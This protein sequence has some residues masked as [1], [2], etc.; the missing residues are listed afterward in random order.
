MP[1]Q[2]SQGDIEDDKAVK[3][4]KPKKAFEINITVWDDAEI[5]TK[6][7][8]YV[9]KERGAPEK[10]LRKPDQF[11]SSVKDRISD[12]PL[13]LL[14]VLARTLNIDLATLLNKKPA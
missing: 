8:E 13:L 4:P 2:Q 7:N 11:V 5:T 14:T 6:L 3:P 10:W 12:D 1:K 9:Q